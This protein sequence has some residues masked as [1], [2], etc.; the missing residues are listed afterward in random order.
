MKYT[1][2]R[3]TCDRNGQ[4][5]I[6]HLHRYACIKNIITGKK[7]LDIASGEGYGTNLISKHASSVI[8]VDISEEAIEHAK[9]KYRSNNISF[10]RGSAENI[11]LSDNSIDVV[12]SF[13][14][15]EHLENHDK[16]LEE[17]KRVMTKN[18]MLVIS[19]PD[20]SYYSDAANY[21]NE[22][23]IKELYADEFYS[24]I[25]KY[26]SNVEM[27]YQNFIIGS[28]I[29]MP[30]EKKNII[31]YSGNYTQITEKKKLT[32]TFCLCIASDNTIVKL[33]NSIF[34]GNNLYYKAEDAYNDRINAVYN[35]TSYKIGNTFVEP[36]KKLLSIFKRQ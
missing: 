34:Y 36:V 3:L 14:T 15:L 2:E 5:A 8:G 7:V 35:S 16:M 31:E 24:L 11:P 17:I 23:H 28:V 33:D 25:K 4:I 21:K 32:H 13:E 19:S 20:K 12:I 6:E 18:G 30:E 10:I 29:S 27:Y 26:F 22:F 9:K 1:G